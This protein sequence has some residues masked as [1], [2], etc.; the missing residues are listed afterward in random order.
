VWRKRI[1]WAVEINPVWK[2]QLAAQKKARAK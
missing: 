1:T 2:Y